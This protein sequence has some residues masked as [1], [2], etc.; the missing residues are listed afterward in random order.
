MITLLLLVHLGIVTAF[1][2]RILVRHDLT[3]QA[4]LAWFVV[5]MVLPLFGSIIYMLFGEIDLG[6]KANKNHARIYA[7]I[8]EKA[9]G[10]MGEPGE[11]STLIAP[12]YQSIFSYTGSIIGFY[13]VA[14][15]SAT[16]LPDATVTLHSIVADIDAATDH[17]HV[18][19]YIWLTDNTGT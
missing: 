11:V 14:E 3:P 18:L 1:T 9:A 10:L 6:N 12:L 15:N 19:Y 16:L 17:V 13:P 8:R 4:R 7:L 2:L 5:L